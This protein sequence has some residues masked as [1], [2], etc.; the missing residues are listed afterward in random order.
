MNNNTALGITTGVLIY[1]V[2]LF[3]FFS[4]APSE[5]IYGHSMS[6]VQL[7][8][9]SSQNSTVTTV[10]VGAI[11]I[12]TQ[13]AAFDIEGLPIWLTFIAVYVPTVLLALGIYGLVRGI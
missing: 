9:L 5:I 6:G 7:N 13:F 10:D 8:A 11:T 12:F 3:I 1:F 2:L 4:Q